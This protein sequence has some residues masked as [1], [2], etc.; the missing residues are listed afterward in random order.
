MLHMAVGPEGEGERQMLFDPLY[1]LQSG[2]ILV[3]DRG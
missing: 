3:L 1:F 2:D